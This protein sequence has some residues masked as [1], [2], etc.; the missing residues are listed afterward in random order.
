MK[1]K[2]EADIKAA[3]LAR[4]N[5][6]KEILKF[7]KSEIQRKEGGLVILTDEEIQKLMRNQIE[8]LKLTPSDTSNEEIKVLEAYLPKMMDE[9]EI[10]VELRFLKSGAVKL[11]MP[12]IMKHFSANF[13]GKVDN[14]VVSQLAKEFI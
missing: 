13:K 10:K 2:I 1:A 7:I 3:M 6:A 9:E 11:D 14:K 12:T 8:S 4:N 5:V